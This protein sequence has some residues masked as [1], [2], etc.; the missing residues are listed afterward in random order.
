MLLNFNFI[1]EGWGYLLSPP[2][3]CVIIQSMKNWILL[4][5]LITLTNDPP[6]SYQITFKN[7][8]KWMHYNTYSCEAP[9]KRRAASLHWNNNY[10]DYS[11]LPNWSH[12]PGWCSNLVCLPCTY[13]PISTCNASPSW[14]LILGALPG[15]SPWCACTPKWKFLSES[16]RFNCGTTSTPMH[17]NDIVPISKGYIYLPGQVD[18]IS[19][20]DCIGIQKVHSLVILCVEGN[21]SS[22]TLS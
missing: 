4:D 14:T 21:R 17:Y 2:S 22:H 20:T 9:R 12:S 11:D 10:S 1:N 15:G 6:N 5:T 16:D 8:I 7:H 3:Y 19:P 13:I 18:K